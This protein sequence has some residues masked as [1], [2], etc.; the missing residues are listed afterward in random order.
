MSVSFDGSK[1]NFD[2]PPFKGMKKQDIPW[3]S[4][5][6]LV[7]AFKAVGIKGSLKKVLK[8]LQSIELLL[9]NK[10]KPYEITLHKLGI[11]NSWSEYKTKEFR[12]KVAE[13]VANTLQR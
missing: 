5:N 10:R 6:H 8:D 11:D 7:Q 2:S 13:V 4:K 1:P 9:R 12:T 3:T